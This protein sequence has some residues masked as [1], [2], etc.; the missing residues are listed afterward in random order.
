M[1]DVGIGT[2]LHRLPDT[3]IGMEVNQT[4]TSKM[5]IVSRSECTIVE[6]H[7]IKI[8]YSYIRTKLTSKCKMK[9]S[10]YLS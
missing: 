1:I 7:F 10:S 4:I 5:K 9:C 2:L 8:V 6:K 3:Q